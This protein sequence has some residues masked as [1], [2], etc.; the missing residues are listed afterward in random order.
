[1]NKLTPTVKQNQALNMKSILSAF[2]LTLAATA[3]FSAIAEISFV[4]RSTITNASRN[5]E[6]LNAAIGD[7]SVANVGSIDFVNSRVDRSEVVNVSFNRN[8]LNAAIG[9]RSIANVGTI[10]VANARIDRSIIINNSQND[11]VVNAAIGNDS[12]ANVGSISIR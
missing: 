12:V 8:V 3:S 2:I 9:G 6:V 1:M 4:S 7:L 11:N 10:Y 5:I